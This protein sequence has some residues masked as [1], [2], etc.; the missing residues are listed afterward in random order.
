MMGNQIAKSLYQVF[1][2]FFLNF[3]HLFFFCKLNIAT[4]L[5]GEL[6]LS[7]HPL[8]RIQTDLIPIL[9]GLSTQ[10]DSSRFFK[11]NDIKNTCDIHLYRVVKYSY[12]TF[13]M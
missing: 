7:L 5:A 4:V 6:P 12:K 10:V 1:F 9:L 3:R 2:F 8:A 13:L 11:V